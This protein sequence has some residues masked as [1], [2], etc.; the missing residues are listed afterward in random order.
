MLGCALLPAVE[1]S[2]E[3]RRFLSRLVHTIGEGYQSPLH[4]EVGMSRYLC[5]KCGAHLVTRGKHPPLAEIYPPNEIKW[6]RQMCVICG[7][8]LPCMK[9][10]SKREAAEWRSKRTRLETKMTMLSKALQAF[11]KE[12]GLLSRKERGPYQARHHGE[13]MRIFCVLSGGGEWR[14]ERCADGFVFHKLGEV[15]T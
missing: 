2:S 11:W 13:E 15:K 7:L 14:A 6:S 5:D 10:L 3:R 8:T 9:Y 4:E 12:H 1:G